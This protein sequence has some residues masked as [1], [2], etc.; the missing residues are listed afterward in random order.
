MTNSPLVFLG[1][2][3]EFRDPASARYAVL[4]IPFEGTVSYKTG[5]AGGPMAILDAS[6]QVELFDDEL[7]AEFHH[8]GVVTLPMIQPAAGPDEEMRRVR[9]AAR[10]PVQEGKFLLSLGGEHSITA[11]LVEVVSE[12]HGPLSVL[13]IDAHADLRDRYEGTP[14][15]HASVMRR[16][17]EITDRIAQVGIRNFSLEEY[18]SCRAQVDNFITPAVIESDPRWIDRTLDLL[19]ETVY[20]TIDIDGLD[21]ACAP[22]TGTPEPGGMNWRQLL[23]L[24]RRVCTERRVVAAD[25]VEVRPLGANHVTEFLAARLAYKLVAYTQL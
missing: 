13:Q 2:G 11:P 16:V 7:H 5:T 19:G 24:L 15:S 12:K 9:N 4:P 17:L 23:A 14:Q 6:Q 8:A 3:P 21:P 25:I 18:E 20:V 10:P 1:L 22:G